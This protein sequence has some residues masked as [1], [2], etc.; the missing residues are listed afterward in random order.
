MDEFFSIMMRSF[1]Q[2]QKTS[3]STQCRALS[4]GLENVKSL[5]LKHN[6]DDKTK[7][8]IS[9]FIDM[10]QHIPCHDIC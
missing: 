6:L 2:S 1:N 4:T 9:I 5:R 3:I 10:K 8:Q 7:R